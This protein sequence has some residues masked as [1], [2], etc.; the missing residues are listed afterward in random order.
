MNILF[1]H[2]VLVFVGYEGSGTGA[3]GCSDTDECTTNKHNCADEADCTNIAASFTCSCKLGYSGDGV[4]CSGMLSSYVSISKQLQ[5]LIFFF[6]VVYPGFIRQCKDT[7]IVSRPQ[8]SGINK[9]GVLAYDTVVVKFPT[10]CKKCA[11]FDAFFIS[12]T[13]VTLIFHLT[14][15]KK[16]KTTVFCLQSNIAISRPR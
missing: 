13:D 8:V 12:L 2:L 5:Y 14:Q 7:L 1:K 11:F 9:R 15:Q 4:Q 16:K 10:Q 3:G 6:R